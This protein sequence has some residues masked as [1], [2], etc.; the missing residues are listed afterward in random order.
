MTVNNARFTLTKLLAPEEAGR[1]R[2]IVEVGAVLMLLKSAGQ[3]LSMLELS[4][5]SWELCIALRP[6]LA[7]RSQRCC[8]RQACMNR[9]QAV[10]NG[11]HTPHNI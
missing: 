4:F 10:S 3:L 5:K 6:K 9:S 8:F 11:N 2:F 7:S 1:S